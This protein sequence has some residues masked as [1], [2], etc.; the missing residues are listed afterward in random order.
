MFQGVSDARVRWCAVAGLAVALVS[1]RPGRAVAVADAPSAPEAA[2]DPAPGPAAAAASGDKGSVSATPPPRKVEWSPEWPR[3]R[4]WEYAG[5]ALVGGTSLY[6]RYYR[7]LP[8]D[9]KWQGDN[10][11]DGAI[12]SWL[13]ADTTSG[14]AEA[15]KVSDV[16]YWGGVVFPFAVDLPV[17]LLVHRAPGVTWQLLWM[18][19]EANAVAGFMTNALFITAGR[20]RPSHEDCAVDPSYDSLC[21]ATGNNASFPSGHTVGVATAAGL[22]CVH[23]HYLPLYGGGAGATAACIGL[24]AAV[25]ATAISRVVADRHYFTD[26]L[27]GAGLGYAAGYGLPWLLHYR[28]GSSAANEQPPRAMLVPFGG[29]GAVGLGV[30]GFL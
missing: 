4:W 25:A 2:P 20:G 18:D 8:P 9:A 17:T 21:G 23:H 15:G 11:I 5:T 22:V 7:K 26:G 28:Y 12:R 14:R 6:L 30:L 13:R 29:S 16:V 27:I 3:F 24:S 1:A 19:I 10:P